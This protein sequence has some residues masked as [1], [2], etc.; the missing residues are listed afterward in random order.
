M[1]YLLTIIIALT[2]FQFSVAQ[3]YAELKSPVIQDIY[4]KTAK[5][6]LLWRA[7]Y[8]IKY[9]HY[10][11]DRKGYLLG[12]SDMLLSILPDDSCCLKIDITPLN[13]KY[14]T[15]NLYEVFKEVDA[16]SCGYRNSEQAM[17][18]YSY[19]QKFLVGYDST[20][21][22]IL[23]ISGN[24]FTPPLISDFYYHRK[25][26]SDSSMIEYLGLLYYCMT[27]QKIELM[28]HRRKYSVF[29]I[30]FSN[31]KYVANKVYRERKYCRKCP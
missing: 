24:F 31:G 1:R 6:I 15:Y 11:L 14:E 3:C 19:D 10:G 7:H 25:I 18:P 8:A 17:P 29:K 4:Q 13:R 22:Q 12:Y 2:R 20:T 5:N 26:L 27:P 16:Y 9:Y 28:K 23:F 30:H 21:R